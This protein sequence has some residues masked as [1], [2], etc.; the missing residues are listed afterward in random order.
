MVEHVDAARRSRVDLELEALVEVRT[1]RV[2][3]DGRLDSFDGHAE[4]RHG[5]RHAPDVGVRRS[6]TRDDRLVDVELE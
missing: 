2:L 1:L 3:P 4:G 6:I 5:L